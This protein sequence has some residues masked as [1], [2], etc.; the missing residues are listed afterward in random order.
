MRRRCI[1][2]QSKTFPVCDGSHTTQGWICEP[3]TPSA[4]MVFSAGES[5][6]NLAERLA[7]YFQG[8]VA[9]KRSIEHCERLVRLCDSHSPLPH[10]HIKAHHVLV[11]AIDVHLNMMTSLHS[12]VALHAIEGE[13]LSK[14]WREI[15]R[16]IK[17]PEAWRL[18]PPPSVTQETQRI[19]LSHAVLDEPRIE[20]P[21][22]ILR[23][24]YG[25]EIFLCADSIHPGEEWSTRIRES[26]TKSD[27][28]IQLIS[29][30]SLNSTFCA[31]EVGMALALGIQ[32]RLIILD[33]CHPPAYVQHLQ[34][35]SVSR[36]IKRK[37]WLN[38]KEALLESFL[39]AISEPVHQ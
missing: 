17:D 28:F 5:L 4:K 25:A 11:L 8:E 20:R 37:P 23:D 21:L 30:A 24:I 22:N 3:S 27:L 39:Q 9:H 13:P 15:L 7:H 32:I 35:I 26:L 31:F 19:F 34:A 38:D 6:W 36:L 2:G 29:P 18:K 16:C 12:N 33:D 1:C 10:T 14:M